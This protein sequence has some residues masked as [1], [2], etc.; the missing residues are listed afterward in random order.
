MSRHFAIFFTMEPRKR[1][2]YDMSEPISEDD[3]PKIKRLKQSYKTESEGDA[4]LGLGIL[5]FAVV[6][7]LKAIWG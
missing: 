3:P 7:L 6:L 2:C 4:M 5:G 1:I